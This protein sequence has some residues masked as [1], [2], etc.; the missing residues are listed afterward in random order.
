M[1][2]SCP[3]WRWNGVAVAHVFCM[4]ACAV[5]LGCMCAQVYKATW[6]VQTVAVKMLTHT[7]EKQM[8]SFRRCAFSHRL[9][10]HGSCC[11]N[12]RTG[13]LMQNQVTCTSM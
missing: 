6:R 2:Y 8:E 10:A 13:K 12:T 4:P 3:P 9:F 7:T 5:T 1:L 11:S